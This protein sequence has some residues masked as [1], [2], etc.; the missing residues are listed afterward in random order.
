MPTDQ[1]CVQR[2]PRVRPRTLGALL[3]GGFFLFAAIG[4]L[5]SIGGFRG[6]IG[7]IVVQ[8]FGESGL[9]LTAL[10]DVFAVLVIAAE[11]GIGLG[12]VVF[13]RTPRFPAIG[14]G[15]LLMMFSLVLVYIS[16]M[17]SPPA[18]GC[19]GAWG[20]MRN[21]AHMSAYAGL[22]RN[23]GLILLAVWLAGRGSSPSIPNT[24]RRQP[25]CRAG[26]T[27][28]ELLITIAISAILIGIL[29]PAL[30]GARSNAREV[31]TLSSLRQCTEAISVYTRLEDGYLPYLATPGKPRLGGMKGY[32][33]KNMPP[34][35]FK[36]QSALWPTALLEHGID[37]SGLDEFSKYEGPT[38]IQ[39]WLWLTLAAYARPEYWVGELPP[40]TD[41]Y[42]AGV[43]LDE[44]LFPSNKGLLLDVDPPIPPH[45]TRPPAW[46][47][48]F[49][50]G[51]ASTKPTRHPDAEIEGLDRP[52]GSVS[53]RVLTTEN[54]IRGI[55]Y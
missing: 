19:L 31:E 30:R 35:Y 3:L 17:D 37:L 53:W 25:A 29:L 24:T 23:I 26:F 39:G 36:G 2:F 51:S 14:A 1:Y 38:R 55:D 27:L 43:R 6:T 46:N 40:D 18:C 44:T 48:G 15:V 21:N 49:A 9:S 41:R 42:Y 45:T 7:L 22:A 16:L 34:S 54:G 52:F 32:L 28:I 10:T 8:A 11:A 33:W 5:L 47:V 20:L 12:L 50:D 4:K 13:S